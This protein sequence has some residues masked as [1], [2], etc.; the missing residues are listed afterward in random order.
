LNRE[1]ISASLLGYALLI[2]ILLVAPSRDRETPFAPG[3]IILDLMVPVV[4]GQKF[5]E[6]QSR[7]PGGTTFPY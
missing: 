1:R 2:D 6:H 3:I 5:L 7:D 4:G